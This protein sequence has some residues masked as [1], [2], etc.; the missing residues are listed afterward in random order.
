MTKTEKRISYFKELGVQF[1]DKMPE[2]WKVVKGATTAPSGYVWI[3]N[4]KNPFSNVAEYK[5]ALLKLAMRV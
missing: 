3:Y 5:S 1:L 2:G 4:G